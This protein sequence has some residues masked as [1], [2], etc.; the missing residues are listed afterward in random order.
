MIL[1]W[2]KE[3]ENVKFEG[4]AWSGKSGLK[5][6]RVEMSCDN[7]NSWVE[8]KLEDSKHRDQAK[9][10]WAWSKWTALLDFSHCNAQQEGVALVRAFDGVQ[11]QPPLWDGSIPYMNNSYHSV[12]WKS[13]I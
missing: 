6:K 11:Q 2:E 4:V 5:V 13:K 7:G 12:N 3:G 1:D 9:R 10:H 8:A